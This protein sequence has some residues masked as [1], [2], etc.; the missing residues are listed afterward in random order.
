MQSDF[1]NSLSLS[2]FLIFKIDPPGD[3]LIREYPGA[4]KKRSGDIQTTIVHILKLHFFLIAAGRG[5]E[6]K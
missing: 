6:N 5:G 3:L 2:R 1:S 4:S